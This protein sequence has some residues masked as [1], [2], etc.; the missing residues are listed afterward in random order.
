MDSATSA[1]QHSGE[2]ATHDAELIAEILRRLKKEE[3]VAV[4]DLEGL[5][6]ASNVI[7]AGA[8]GEVRAARTATRNSSDVA[9]AVCL[10]SVPPSDP[11][12]LLQVRKVMWRKTPAAAKIAKIDLSEEEKQLFL[13]ELDVMARC[14]HPNIV[15]FLGYVDTPFVIVMEWLPMGDLKAYWRSRDVPTSH[16]I[17]ICIDVLRALAYLHN[18]KP[19][20]IIHRDIKPTNVLMTRSGVA[21]LTD[22]GLGRFFKNSDDGSKHGGSSVNASPQ[23]LPSPLRQLKVETSF[24]KG[25]VPMAPTHMSTPPADATD[26]SHSSASEEDEGQQQKQA[27][28]RQRLKPFIAVQ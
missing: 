11:K 26:G 16:K 17:Q 24:S 5:E 18:R 2:Q 15:Q 9:L 4:G 23:M 20:A 19:S 21:K 12:R 27:S 3:E 25:H 14:R 8:F 22:F 10:G 6:D 13:R 7:G 28:Q 1:V